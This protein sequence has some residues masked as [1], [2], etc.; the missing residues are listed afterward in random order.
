MESTLPKDSCKVACVPV[1]MGN[2]RV[3]AGLSE[4]I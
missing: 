2:T 4:S 1:V 3:D